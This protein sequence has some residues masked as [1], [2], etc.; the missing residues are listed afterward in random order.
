MVPEELIDGFARPIA[1]VKSTVRDLP[2]G[3][4]LA[5]VANDGA[6]LYL[7]DRHSKPVAQ[8]INTLSCS[9]T[10]ASTAVAAR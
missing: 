1:V 3:V 8:K 9:V 4:S 6:H 5:G 7:V 10:S 2:D